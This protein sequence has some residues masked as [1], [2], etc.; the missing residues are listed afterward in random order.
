MI[1]LQSFKPKRVEPSIDT[2]MTS[3]RPD[4]DATP[5]VSSLL[6]VGPS[7]LADAIKAHSFLADFRCRIATCQDKDLNEIL[8]NPKP[9]QNALA[10]VLSSNTV[11]SAHQKHL[12]GTAG[13]LMTV[14]GIEIPSTL[15]SLT[16]GMTLQWKPLPDGT[17][18]LYLIEVLGAPVFKLGAFKSCERYGR[19]T[20][21]RRYFKKNG[22]PKKTPA[23]PSC[24]VVNFDSNH[25]KVRKLVQISWTGTCDD[26]LTDGGARVE[27][28]ATE[29]ARRR[30]P[31]S[32]EKTGPRAGSLQYG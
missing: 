2:S 31:Q 30:S 4:V 26:E 29:Q 5:L 19:T 12:A 21:H 13:Y 8:A 28:T 14:L 27:E 18:W 3:F 9:L 1:S 11:A 16:D 15:R 22:D 6:A 10:A 23:T 20:I 32:V 24:F 7:A 17:I 25:I